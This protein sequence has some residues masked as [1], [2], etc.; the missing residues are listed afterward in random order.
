MRKP[1]VV[2][3]LTIWSPTV[4]LRQ[5]F[6][7]AVAERGQAEPVIVAAELSDRSIGYGET[8]ARP[9]VTGETNE[10]VH[11]TIEDVLVPLLVDLRAGSFFEAVEA[12]AVL[13]HNDESG[14]VIAAA[15]AAVELAV[16]DAYS[17]AFARPLSTLAGWLGDVGLGEPGSLGRVRYSG[18]VSAEDPR[19]AAWT[20][21][22]MRLFG[23]GD[24]KMKVGDKQDGDRLAAAL[25]V[26][27]RPIGR[28]RATLRLDANGA[29]T[30]EQAVERLQAWGTLPIASVEQPVAK[31]DLDGWRQ[32]ALQIKRPLMADES[33]VTP[34]DGDRFARSG[35]AVGFNI[36]IS[37]NGGLIPA[38]RLAM[39]ARKA[40]LAYQL[41][42]MVGETSI[43]SAVG[44]WFLQIVPG[45][46][47]AEGSFGGFLLRGDVT[48]RSIRFGYGGRW[49]P[50]SGLGLGIEVVPERLAALSPARPK[51][52]VL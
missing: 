22:K 42:C 19:R 50:L 14:R 17:R 18:V 51:R 26:L 27:G 1:I 38:I 15:R 44:R 10:D 20:I 43:L 36:R 23:L 31:H 49:S 52:I 37:K 39:T 5:K 13:P 7:H 21:R 25:R 28:S 6:R 40:G 24:F 12:I 8:H 29:W 3:Q 2:R 47:F 45:V 33:L 46:R 4:P 9:Y 11:R 35:A 48:R 30:A 16:L 34:E 41:G 32:L